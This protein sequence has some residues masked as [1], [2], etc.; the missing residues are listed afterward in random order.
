MEPPD[1]VRNRAHATLS[2]TKGN[3]TAQWH[4]YGTTGY[5]WTVGRYGS[6]DGHDIAVRWRDPYGIGGTEVT[7]GILNLFDAEPS[8]NSDLPE[9]PDESL[10][11]IRGR[12]FFAS[13]K[14]VW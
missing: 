12:T 10:D 1:F 3:V 2:A 4:A 8:I 5:R 14:K 11:S 6:W 9:Y 13:L 7:G